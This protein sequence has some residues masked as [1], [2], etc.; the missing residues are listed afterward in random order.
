MKNKS[1]SERNLSYIVPTYALD[2][3][4]EFHWV[5]LSKV[6]GVGGWDDWDHSHFRYHPPEL[7]VLKLSKCKQSH[8]WR[9]L[10]SIYSAFVTS[11][12]KN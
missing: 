7:P 9:Q 6:R 8:C 10:L 1:F 3:V 2:F 12:S 11:H 5:T 4:A